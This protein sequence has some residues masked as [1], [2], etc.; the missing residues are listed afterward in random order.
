MQKHI[1]NSLNKANNYKSNIDNEVLNIDGMTGVKTRHLYNNLCSLDN[2]RYLEI[3][4]WKGSSICS[5]MS[6]NNITCLCIDNW[7]KFEGSGANDLK[8]YF[9]ENIN[10]TF[11][12]KKEFINNFNKCKGSNNAKYI[13]NNCWD[14]CVNE[15]GKFNIYMYDGE[16]SEKSHFLALKY[17]LPC[18]DKEFIYIIDDWNWYSVQTGMY[19]SIIDNSCEII[20]KTEIFTNDKQHPKWG[21]GEGIRA[22]K[23]GDWHNGICIFILRKPI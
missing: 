2:I 14:I 10:D 13:E 19:N 16:H 1:E 4:S 17:Y 8:E 23:H 18:L 11:S 15:I 7:C 12:V 5:A 21:N 3:G 6:N 20:Y 22:G 9:G